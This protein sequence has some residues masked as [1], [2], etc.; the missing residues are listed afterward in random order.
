MEAME[1]YFIW[2]FFLRTHKPWSEGL[3]SGAFTQYVSA[4][5]GS[6]RATIPGLGSVHVYGPDSCKFRRAGQTALRS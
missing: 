6:G 5:L 2:C 3:A 4:S 1:D